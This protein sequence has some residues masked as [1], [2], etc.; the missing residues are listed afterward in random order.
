MTFS[1]FNNHN[2][3]A[4]LSGVASSYSYFARLL[5]SLYPRRAQNDLVQDLTTNTD[6]A[7]PDSGTVAAL[8]HAASANEDS[9]LVV[10]EAAVHVAF[11]KD[12]VSQVCLPERRGYF[13]FDC[14]QF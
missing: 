8:E 6:V 2:C 3:F 14:L 11:T 9:I 4:I 10:A 5:C 12:K 7:P 13:F 1:T